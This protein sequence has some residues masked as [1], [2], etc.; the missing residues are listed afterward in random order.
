MG[1]SNFNFCWSECKT[2][3]EYT[4][5]FTDI[6][7]DYI[8]ATQSWNICFFLWLF[9]FPAWWIVEIEFLSSFVYTLCLAL[10]AGLFGEVSLAEM[11]LK[12]VLEN[13]WASRCFALA[14]FIFKYILCLLCACLPFGFPTL[15][16]RINVFSFLY[17]RLCL[18]C[19]L[20]AEFITYMLANLIAAAIGKRSRNRLKISWLCSVFTLGVITAIWPIG[21]RMHVNFPIVN[22]KRADIQM[23]IQY[24]VTIV[25]CYGYNRG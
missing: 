1:L 19:L 9:T 3:T 17:P 25:S 11:Y 13:T 24:P 2:E 22:L 18:V 15:N 14:S 16:N 8:P 23:H 6:H 20:K 4:T 10:Y 12:H 7:V 21:N 5:F